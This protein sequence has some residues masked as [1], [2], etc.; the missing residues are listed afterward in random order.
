[1]CFSWRLI[2]DSLSPVHAVWTIAARTS[3][4]I[5]VS[6]SVVIVPDT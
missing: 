3:F 6:L 5:A 4:A 1:M 2:I